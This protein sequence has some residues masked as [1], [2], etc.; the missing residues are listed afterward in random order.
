M[1]CQTGYGS[2]RWSAEICDC[3]LPMTFDTYS[4]CSYGCAYCFS[5][6]QRGTG[7]G[8]DAYRAKKVRSVSVERVKRIFTGEVDSQFRPFIEARKTIQWGGL[9]DQFDGYERVYGKTLELLR[10]FKEIDYPLCFSTKATWWLDDPR[11]RELFEGQRNWHCK[12]SIITMD[13][14]VAAR[15]EK[16][17]PTPGERIEA[18]AKYAELGAGGATLRLRPFIIGISSRDYEELIRA[19]AAAGAISMTT[20]FFCLEQRAVGIA[21]E[22]YRTLS[23][24][25]GH[26]IYDFYRRQSR[27]GGYL[28]LNR[29]VKEPYVRDMRRIARECGIGFYVSDAH[30]KEASDGKCCCGLDDSWNLAGANFA[31]ALQICK[32]K[33]VVTFSE[34][35][36]DS[37]WLGFDWARAEGY[38]TH[39]IETR[40]EY[41]GLTM[42]DYIRY[43]WNH[44]N[45][46]QS[47]Y[48]YFGGVMK[49]VGVD[50]RGDV[51]Y[52]YD[53]SRTFVEGGERDGEA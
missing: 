46:G 30:F 6:Y 34:I 21:R 2:P 1:S 11:Y 23:D 19:S 7:A 37:D 17:C 10:F 8:G 38:N 22:G 35:M 41:D 9:S 20:E 26:D 44:P 36:G 16:H 31:E 14:A 50:E 27:G 40:A 28:R 42:R 43:K 15:V 32:R 4:N 47:P 13:E 45:E 51:V 29:A 25:I 12:F 33:G 39:S 49:P 5:Q 18:I 24:V 3:S 53:E 48:V 52:A